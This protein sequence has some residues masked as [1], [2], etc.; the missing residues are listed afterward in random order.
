MK[1]Y[2]LHLSAGE[3]FAIKYAIDNVMI[4]G[5]KC[6]DRYEEE[7]VN[8]SDLIDKFNEAFFSQETELLE[9]TKTK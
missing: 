6:F 4:N 8:Y 7:I 3:I 5:V 9:K 1:K 2:H